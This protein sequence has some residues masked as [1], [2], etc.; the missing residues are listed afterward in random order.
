VYWP[1]DQHEAM[2]AQF[3]RV[4]FKTGDTVGI[5]INADGNPVLFRL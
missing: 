2:V 5:D 4:G 3:R 1:A